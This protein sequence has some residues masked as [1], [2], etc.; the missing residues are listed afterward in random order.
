VTEFKDE[1]GESISPV[2]NENL[3]HLS[4]RQALNDLAHFVEQMM[5]KG[6]SNL[7]VSSMRGSSTIPLPSNTIW[8]TFGGSYPGML[9][10][11]ARLKYPHLIHA[12]VSNS[13]PIQSK[14]DMSDYNDRVAWDLAYTDIGGSQQCLE[15][16]QKGHE[17][18]G[19]MMSSSVGK[20]TIAKAFHF[21]NESAL[22]NIDNVN[23]FLGDGVITINAQSNDPSCE[24]PLC[25]IGKVRHVRW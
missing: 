8:V 16:V 6:P 7:N 20:Q 9:A 24:E 14:L 19:Q 5:E 11:W 4:S 3:V 1:N 23:A 10:G 25:N 13:A 15:I 12:A 2:T 22:D 21:C 17:E 18:I